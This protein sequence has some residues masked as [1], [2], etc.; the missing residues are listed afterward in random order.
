MEPKVKR[1]N[2]ILIQGWMITDLNLKGNELLIYA[3]IYGF[4]QAENQVFNG[5]LQYLADWTN[6]SKRTVISVL[7]SLEDKNLITKRENYINGVKF[8]EYFVNN[9]TTSEKISPVVKNLQ[10]GGEKIS[11]GGGEKISP[12]NIYKDN[13]DNNIERKKENKKESTYDENNNGMRSNDIGVC[14]QTTYKDKSIKDKSIKDK[15]NNIYKNEFESLWKEYPRKIGKPNALKDYI[16]AR[17]NGTS[18]EDIKKGIENYNKFLKIKGWSS[19]YIKQGSTWFHQECWTDEYDLTPTS[20]PKQE[21]K[22]QE[23]KGL[24]KY[25]L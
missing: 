19:E 18:F 1:E 15:S 6:S 9:F 11:L 5:S 10:G 16:K 2:F 21:P 24:A 8:C 14:V 25:Q 23:L 12:Y 17:N 3:C 7:Q 4:S 13:I 20:Q 22:N